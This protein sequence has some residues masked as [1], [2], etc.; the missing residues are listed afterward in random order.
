MPVHALTALTEEYDVVSG[1][2][3]PLELGDHRLVEAV[4]SRPRVL[5]GDE[6]GHQVVAQLDPQGLLDVTGLA[7]L[8]EGAW[9][10]CVCHVSTLVRHAMSGPGDLRAQTRSSSQSSPGCC[11]PCPWTTTQPTS[12]TMA[13]SVV[14]VTVPSPSPRPVREGGLPNQSA[15]DAPSGLVRM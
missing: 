13:A 5:S 9:R 8:S 15:N 7:E 10:G 12:T 3:G 14:Q 2:E 6:L 11:T 4:Q 1:E